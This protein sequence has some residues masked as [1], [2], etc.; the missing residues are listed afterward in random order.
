MFSRIRSSML[1]FAIFIILIIPVN[2][3]GQT[4][5]VNWTDVHQQIDG[6][7]GEDWISAESLTSSQAAMFFSPSTGIGLEYVR[8][9]NYGCPET[10]A[11][12]VSTANV[13]DLTTLQEAVANG[14]KIELGISP[15]ANLQYGGNFIDG[16][17]DPS[18]GNCIDSSNWSAFATFTVNWIEMLNANS[19]TV[20][21]LSVSNE[22]NLKSGNTLGGCI[23]SAAGLDSYI[24]HYLGPALATAGLSSSV[25]VMLPESSNWFNTDLVS[26]CLDDSTCSQ[27]VSIAAGHDYAV[28]GVDGTDNGYCCITASAA[29]SSASSKHIWMSEV[30]GGLTFNSTANL[31]NWDASM[32]DAL[33]WAH[34]VHDFLTVANV[35]GYEYWQLADCCSS[36]AG[37]PFNDGL[38][39][40]AFATSKR[41]YTI[42]QWSKFVR[43]GYYRID[44]TTN[45]QSGVYVTAFQSTSSGTL[46]VVAVNTNGSNTSQSFTL[47]NAPPF[48]TVTPYE[49]S[50]SLSLSA[51]AAVSLSSNA[52]TYTLPSGSVTTFVG[53][54][55]VQPPVGLT[56]QAH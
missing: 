46:V 4:S 25:K 33:I 56:A 36:E 19:A 51:Q 54:S 16:T 53:S 1:T 21:V 35:S 9:Q 47:T 44:S 37:G 32:T 48:S 23:W 40:A 10:G 24:G 8:T 17:A 7:G 28:G 5:T 22:P 55:T 20:S 18:T 39:T 2:I 26:T 43:S 42:G 6:W 29:P 3:L 38:T 14:A 13:P 50:A 15:P 41:F 12:A 11:C 30:N 27:Y 34:N 49:T 45:P 31:W 52:F